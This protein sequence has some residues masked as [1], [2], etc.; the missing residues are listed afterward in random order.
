MPEHQGKGAA[1][2]LIRWGLEQADAMGLEAYLEA[3]PTARPVYEHFGFKTVEE[4][5]PSKVH[6][7]ESFMIRSP[8]NLK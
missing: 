4:F 1:G 8:K 5:R 3:S 6:H 2:R 7:V